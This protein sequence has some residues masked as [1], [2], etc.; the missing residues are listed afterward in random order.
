MRFYSRIVFICNICFIIAAVMWKIERVRR[1]HGNSNGL[2]QFQPLEATLVILGY[3]A[4]FL[5][6]VFVFLS[7]YWLLTKKIKLIP[8]WII[9]F[10][11][12]IFPLQVYYHF[13]LH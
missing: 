1:S 13:I 4:I 12:L 11:L 2:I 9:L 6:L 8:R 3:S 7:L 5:N 10:N